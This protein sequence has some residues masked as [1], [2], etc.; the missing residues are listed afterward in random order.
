MGQPND[1]AQTDD[2]GQGQLLSEKAA[3]GYLAVSRSFLAKARMNG[4]L[5]GHTAGPPFIKLG[6]AVRYRR[7]DLDQ[8]LNEHRHVPTKVA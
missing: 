3:C 4:R 8:W 2:T 7:S 6:R 5:S 1:P